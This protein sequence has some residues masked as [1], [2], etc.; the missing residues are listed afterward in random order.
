MSGRPLVLPDRIKAAVMLA[1][2]VSLP[3][4]LLACARVW[5]DGLGGI[6]PGRTG[7]QQDQ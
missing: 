4:V 3:L 1:N 2:E 7:G 6:G 5:E